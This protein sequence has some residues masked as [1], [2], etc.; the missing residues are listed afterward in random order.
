MA[1]AAAAP[2]VVNLYASRSADEEPRLDGR[3]RHE[4]LASTST[5]ANATPSLTQTSLGSGV[6]I[7]RPGLIVTNGHVVRDRDQ[8]M[9]ELITATA[10]RGSARALAR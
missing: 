8:I 9:V 1:G 5:F 6:I 3:I 10:G 7:G 4:M 2:A